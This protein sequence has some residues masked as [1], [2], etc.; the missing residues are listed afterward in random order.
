MKPKRK[1]WDERGGWRL[2]PTDINDTMHCHQIRKQQL[3]NKFHMQTAF[4]AYK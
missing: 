3:T 4:S 1:N 2:A